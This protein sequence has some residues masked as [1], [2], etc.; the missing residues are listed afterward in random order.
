M[1]SH[2]SRN[3]LGITPDEEA[4]RDQLA[5]H[6][7]PSVELQRLLLRWEIEH[8]G[9]EWAAQP[10]PPAHLRW[11][12]AHS[13]PLALLLLPT[14]RPAD[15]LA[16]LHFYGA[17][18]IGSDAA[19]ALLRSWEDGFGAQLV[20]HWGTMLQFVVE[21]PAETLEDA[22][23]LAVEQVSLAPCTAAKGGVSLRDHA[24]ALLH[25][26]TWFLHERP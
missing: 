7:D 21:R 19:V 18:G 22:F 24:R 20:A 2:A 14:K 17:E 23:Q 9:P 26:E 12:D 1:N 6:P 11:F 13:E 3:E 16:W 25:L 8:R 10:A 15:A 4:L 5:G